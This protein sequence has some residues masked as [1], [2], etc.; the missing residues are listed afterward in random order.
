MFLKKGFEV[1]SIC[2]IILETLL[3]E[4]TYES[5]WFKFLRKPSK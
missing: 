3:Q 2:N 1:I 4:T 5:S